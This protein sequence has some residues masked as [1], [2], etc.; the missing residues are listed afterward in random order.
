MLLMMDTFKNILVWTEREK[1][2]LELSI[3]TFIKQGL[4][5]WAPGKSFEED[6]KVQK[7]QKQNSR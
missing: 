3:L 2:T 5:E 1:R 6:R 7:H 4:Y